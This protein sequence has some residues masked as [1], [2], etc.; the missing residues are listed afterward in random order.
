MFKKMMYSIGSVSLVFSMVMVLASLS[1]IL[2]G[3][4][5]TPQE[6]GE[7]SLVRTLI[8]VIPPL[9]V[10]GQDVSTARFFSRNQPG[11]Y[12]WH[13]AFYR[14]MLIGA[15]LSA[16]GI[17]VARMI[18][19]LDWQMCLMLYIACVAYVSTLFSSNLWRG[20]QSYIPAI[21]MLNGF[22][23]AFFLFVLWWG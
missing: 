14:I 3:R 16:I 19:K 11:E 1:T 12:N 21:L 18:Y 10:W 22:R 4:A 7:F 6:F 15:L 13:S 23:G 8:L 9:A 17:G 20:K 2:L 5:L